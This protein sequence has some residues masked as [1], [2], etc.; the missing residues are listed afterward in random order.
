MSAAGDQLRLQRARRPLPRAGHARADNPERDILQVVRSSSTC[1][2]VS[3]VLFAHRTRQI[4]AFGSHP[5]TTALGSLPIAESGGVKVN[6]T[7]EVQGHLG[8]FALGDVVDT[9]ERKQAAK[10]QAHLA[11]VVPNVVS[12]L[13]GRPLRKEYKGVPEMIV[14]PLGKVGASRVLLDA[15]GVDASSRG[16]PA[17]PGISTSSGVS[18]SETGSRRPLWARICSSRAREGSGV[19]EG[20]YASSPAPLTV[21]FVLSSL[22]ILFADNEGA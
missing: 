16:R 15:A 10:G 18:Y 22:I 8:I 12:L 19:F 7:M 13:E 4:P 3:A 1:H 17:G 9:A 11:V 5:N 20:V 14:I 6:P 2:A 21:V